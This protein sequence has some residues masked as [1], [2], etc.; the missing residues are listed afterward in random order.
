MENVKFKNGDLEIDISKIVSFDP[1][2]TVAKAYDQNLDYPYALDVE[3]SS[4][5][6][7]N[8]IDRDDDFETL[9]LIVPQFSFVE[10]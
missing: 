4:Y 10:I 9:K 5:F 6:Y 2:I 1:P 7:S 3:D 8:Q